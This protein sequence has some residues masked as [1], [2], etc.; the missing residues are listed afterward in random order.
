MPTSVSV[1]LTHVV[2]RGEPYSVCMIHSVELRYVRA[3]FVGCARC[4]RIISNFLHHIKQ[5]DPNHNYTVRQRKPAFVLN[6]R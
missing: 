3:V 1:G 6:C 4:G 2:P 5:S